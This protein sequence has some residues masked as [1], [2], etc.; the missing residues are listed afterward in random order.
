MRYRKFLFCIAACL[1]VFAMHANAET[2]VDITVNGTYIQV[3][4][5]PVIESGRTLVPVRSV[6]NALVFDRVE[7][8][9]AAKKVTVSDADTEI[10]LKI[11]DKTAV[12]NGVRKQMDTAAKLI[13]DRTYVPVR[14]VSEAMGAEVDWNHKLYTVEIT[15]PGISVPGH[16]VN[17]DY[18]R[19][20]LDWLAKIVHAEAQGESHQGKVAVANVIMNRIESTDFPDTVYEVVF[21]RKYGV[22][23]T[24]VANGAIY[25]NPAQESYKAAK[26]ALYGKDEAGESLYFC[27]PRTSTSSWI[28]NNRPFY[29]S[30]GNH[31]FFL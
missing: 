3:D 18:T 15:K 23:F 9:G 12:V 4:S 24:P 11:G 29:K 7:W 19:E 20:D 8:D 2:P 30:I 27:N 5:A 25:N 1:G 26:Q 31:D 16:A 14:F 17:E 28:I 6:S 10:I 21:D 22:Q 13:N